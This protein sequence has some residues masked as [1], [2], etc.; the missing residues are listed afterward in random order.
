MSNLDFKGTIGPAIIDWIRD[1]M[2]I[3]V[4]WDR[5]N[6]QRPDIPY[7][8]LAKVT[9]LTKIGRDD[10]REHVSGDTYNISGQRNFVLSVQAYGDDYFE[11]EEIMIL[12]QNSLENPEHQETLRGAGLA[13][14]EI[15]PVQDTSTELETG[16]EYRANIDITFGVASNYQVDIGYI[17]TT[18]VQGEADG[19]Q[20]TEETIPSP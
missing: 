13:I 6:I 4:I 14:W 7:I 15:G 8:T 2:N 17:E 16:F 12:L 1:V 10:S 20:E 11:A 9:P 5:P 19:E 18:K 3:T